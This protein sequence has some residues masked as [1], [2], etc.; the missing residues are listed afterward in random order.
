[1][2]AMADEIITETA[3]EII[4]GQKS[5]PSFLPPFFFSSFLLI[6][7]RMRCLFFKMHLHNTF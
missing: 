5:L 1:M 7:F 2:E 4:E 3:T 6:Q